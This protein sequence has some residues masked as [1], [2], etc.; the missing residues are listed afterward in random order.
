MNCTFIYCLPTHKKKLSWFVYCACVTKVGVEGAPF[1]ERL[2]SIIGYGWKARFGAPL[3]ERLASIIGYGW[4]ARFVSRLHYF[5]FFFPSFSC[6]FWL[7]LSVCTS[8][9]NGERYILMASYTVY[10]SN[11]F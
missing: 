5:F 4:K 3:A 2:A 6:V 10:S 8:K 1:A 11:Y 9:I 7:F